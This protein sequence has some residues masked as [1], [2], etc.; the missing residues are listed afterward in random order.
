MEIIQ[1]KKTL[2][3]GATVQINNAK[4]DAPVVNLS[5]NDNIKFLENIN[6]G[7]RRTISWNKYWSEITMQPKNNNFDDIIGPT[8]RNIDRLFVLSLMVTMIPREICLIN[9]TCH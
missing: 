3:T 7:S 4:L 5:I 6:Q 1:W 8:I 2:S 9:I